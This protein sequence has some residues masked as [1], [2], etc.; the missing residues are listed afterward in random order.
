MLDARP[1]EMRSPLGGDSDRHISLAT[2]AYAAYPS[3][4]ARLYRFIHAICGKDSGG[5]EV[6]ATGRAQID[7]SVRRPA[8]SFNECVSGR[9]GSVH[10]PQLL[11]NRRDLSRRG[12]AA[13]ADDAAA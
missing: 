6:S 7:S 2:K 3:F 5:I 9:S 1:W 11:R 10:R 13:A 12:A 4:Q 8:E